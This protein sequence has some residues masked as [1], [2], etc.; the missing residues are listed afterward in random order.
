MQAE[1]AALEKEDKLRE[2]ALKNEDDSKSKEELA[3][4]VAAGV[5]NDKKKAK[6]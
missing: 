3:E 6:V 1:V 5:K 4:M 2:K